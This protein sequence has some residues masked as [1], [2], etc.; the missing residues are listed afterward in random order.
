MPHD[1]SMSAAP[2]PSGRVYIS[3]YCDSS[4][5]LKLRTSSFGPSKSEMFRSY[6]CSLLLCFPKTCQ[7]DD[8]DHLGDLRKTPGVQDHERAAVSVAITWRTP[9]CLFFPTLLAKDHKT[10][11]VALYDR[12]S[13]ELLLP[14]VQNSEHHYYDFLRLPNPNFIRTWFAPKLASSQRMRRTGL[15]LASATYKKHVSSPATLR[16]I[17]QSLA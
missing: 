4:S 9:S 7:F 12:S 13:S 1:L 10:L 2:A 15:L 6:G 17:I 3:I 5:S 14:T 11:L 16:S 8:H